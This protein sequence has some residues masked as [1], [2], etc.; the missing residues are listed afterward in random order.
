MEKMEINN[1]ENY[2]PLTGRRLRPPKNSQ[3]VIEYFKMK[4]VVI[5]FFVFLTSLAFCQKKDSIYKKTFGCQLGYSYPRQYKI[6]FGGNCYWSAIPES[7]SF[8][9]VYGPCF[10]LAT[11]FSSGKFHLG[12]QIGFNCHVVSD[13]MP[14]LGFI[15]VCPTFENNYDR[16]RRI[17][18]DVGISIGGLYFYYG[19]YVPVNNH[20]SSDIS[21]SRFGIRYIFNYTL[22][23]SVLLNIK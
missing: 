7:G 22:L 4:N 10:S 11:I 6:D 17:G 20:E 16:D 12:Q 21:R 9:V 23:K 19:Y 8:A 14:F 1:I 13:L 2:N 5:I 18:T 3:L 15:R